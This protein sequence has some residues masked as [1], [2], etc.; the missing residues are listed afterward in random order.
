MAD[1]T[2]EPIPGDVRAWARE[3]GRQVGERGRLNKR[4]IADYKEANV[5]PLEDNAGGPRR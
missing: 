4:L 1:I 2:R 5:W 3:Q